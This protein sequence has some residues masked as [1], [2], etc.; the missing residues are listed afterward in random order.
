MTSGG[1]AAM[2]RLGESSLPLVLLDVD[3]VIVDT[4][5]LDGE[6]RPWEILEVETTRFPAP[7]PYFMPAL[8]QAL[9]EVTE[10][11]W[12]TSW[13]DR[14]NHEIGRHLGIPPLPVVWREVDPT[15][16]DWKVAGARPPAKAALRAGRRVVWIEDFDGFPPERAMPPGVEFVDTSADG[17]GVLL[18]RFLPA[19]LWIPVDWL[20]LPAEWM[21][22]APAT[23]TSGAVGGDRRD[24]PW[25]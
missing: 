15:V 9:F 2:R 25:G 13:G 18:P 1:R 16:E 3:G 22:T 11:W 5:A 6:P 21:G 8:I 23:G 7:I 14:A 24:R 17:T 4:R 10:L 19:D 12:C 20:D